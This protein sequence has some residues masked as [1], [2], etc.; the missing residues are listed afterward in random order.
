[1][2]E[3]ASVVRTA[4][5]VAD[6]VPW[7]LV[8]RGLTAVFS[9]A[10]SMVVVRG[11]GE[12]D[13]GRYSIVQTAL[14]FYT[15]I[16]TFG[17]TEALLKFV[18]AVRGDRAGAGARVIATALVFQLGAWLALL[19]LTLAGAGYIDAL[20]KG[21][22]IGGILKLGAALGAL[23]LVFE[24]M[25]VV[26]T[27]LYRTRAVALATLLARVGSLGFVVLAVRAGWGV[28]GVLIALGAGS[29]VGAVSLLGKFTREVS[30][31]GM[32]LERERIGAGRLWSYA[33]PLVG[34]SFL[35][36]IIWRQSE[37]LIVGYFWGPVLAGYFNLAY[38]LPQRILEFVPL[39]MWPLV[40]AGLSE[41]QAREEKNL[42]HAISLYY[43]F[44]FLLVVPVAVYGVTLGDK[45]VVVLYGGEMAQAG[46]LSRFFFVV[47]LIAFL[48]TPLHM[49]TY[50]VEKTWANLAVGVAGAVVTLGLDLILIP[51]YGIYGGVPPT[52][53][54]L[55][56]SNWLQYRLARRF[57][58]GLSVPWTHL[59]KVL[60]ASGVILL[61]YPLRWWADGAVGF[62]ALSALCVLLFFI[63]ARIARVLGEEER[64][65]LDGSGWRA[66]R[67]LG[68]LLY[69]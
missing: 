47:F 8:A 50:V 29:S 62:L 21:V 17:M 67:L 63:A 11:L 4:G 14:G 30:P 57:V 38:S 28:P 41:V 6:A 33:L 43:R 10:F 40:L 26:F 19:V 49:A 59:A 48:G 2:S 60:A 66:M 44:L 15:I 58:P 35:G 12:Y 1:M 39:A 52:T 53:L 37:A 54:G 65:L 22:R 20:Y 5:K 56:I 32:R 69:R 36:Q 42:P 45:A 51:R 24:S 23:S 46:A 55:I 13:Y 3:N 61:A 18:P 34:R 25:C 27:G 7:N 31:K 68:R 16:Y 9:I 64:R